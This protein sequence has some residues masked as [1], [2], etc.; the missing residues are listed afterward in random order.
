MKFLPKLSVSVLLSLMIL[1]G[2][3]GISLAKMVCLKSGNSVIMM[4]TPDDCCAHEHEH[5]PV[6]IEEKCCDISNLNVDALHFL[7]SSSA[8]FE[9]AV[10]CAALPVQ[11]N[12][13]T[14]IQ[15]SSDEFAPQQERI[16]DV[17]GPAIRIFTKSFLI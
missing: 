2:G 11:I 4:N 10:S 7:V 13:F 1:I 15:F 17:H 12:I 14:A 3:S 9:K 6:T 8:H 5:A 16:P